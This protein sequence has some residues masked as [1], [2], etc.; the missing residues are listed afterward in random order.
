[1]CVC[2][3]ACVRVYVCVLF[4]LHGVLILNFGVF[5]HASFT[6][7]VWHGGKGMNF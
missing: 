5:N 6:K 2:V 4:I 1:M 3:S 7:A